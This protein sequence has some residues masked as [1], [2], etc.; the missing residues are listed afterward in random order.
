[1]AVAAKTRATTLVG[2]RLVLS[3]AN[4]SLMLI[5]GPGPSPWPG[6]A[7]SPVGLVGGGGGGGVSSGMVARMPVFLLVLTW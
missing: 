6:R 7:G 5:P 3:G 4:S 2:G 1:M